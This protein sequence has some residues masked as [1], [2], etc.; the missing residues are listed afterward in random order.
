MAEQRRPPNPFLRQKNRKP[1]DIYEI[2]RKG[3][4]GF[5]VLRYIVEGD[6]KVLASE[7]A[8][9]DAATLEGA[10]ALVPRGLF[11]STREEEDES[12]LIET[13]L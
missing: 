7:R 10:R 9:L 3:P 4:Q 8:C 12:T 6:M 11:C 5:Q 1:L 2:H 13:W